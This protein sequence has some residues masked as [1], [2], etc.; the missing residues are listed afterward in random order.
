MSNITLCDSVSFLVENPRQALAPIKNR[1]MFLDLMV[2]MNCMVNTR[3]AICA[4]SCG[5]PGFALIY[6]GGAAVTSIGIEVIRRVSA[7][8]EARNG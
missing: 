6:L 5:S 3:I 2:I 4:F 8:N 7:S 1:C